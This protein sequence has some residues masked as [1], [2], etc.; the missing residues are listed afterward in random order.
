MTLLECLGWALFWVYAFVFIWRFRA[1]FFYAVT[2]LT[3]LNFISRWY[4]W[5]VR[6]HIRRRAID[7][8]LRDIRRIDGTAKE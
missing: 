2:S 4:L 1:K 3:N 8:L 5:R 6:G 7:K